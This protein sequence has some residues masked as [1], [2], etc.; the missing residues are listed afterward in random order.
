MS[1][2]R[3]LAPR[4]AL[5]LPASNPRAIAKAR[6]LAV[7]MV[8]LDLEDAVKLEDK[9][10][11]R[12]AAVAAAAEGFGPRLVAIRVN[13][14]DA[15]E[16]ETDLTAVAGSLA[17]FAVVPK[18]ETAEEAAR[19]AAASA[20]P[21]LAM[22]ETPLGV[23]AAA[24]IAAAPGVAGLIAGVNDLRATLGIP[25]GR[26]GLTLALQTIVL[27]ARAS[28]GWAIDGVFNALDD[29]EG[30]AAECREGRAMGFDGKSLIHPNQIAIAAEAFGPTAEELADARALIEAATGGAERFRDRMIEAMHVEQAR[31][32]IERAER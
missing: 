17:D 27:A 1:T 9:G 16:H 15:A 23:L 4:T 28:A 19:I 29:P 32:L 8:I 25:S 24:D 21:L 20:K 2:S 13:G 14:G 26:A 11:A 6:E 18:V 10:H 5:F 12:R 31:A 22:I 7:D 3:R 30:L